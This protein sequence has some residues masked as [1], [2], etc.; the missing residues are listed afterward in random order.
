[1]A[2]FLERE[3]MDS[4]WTRQNFFM[5]PVKSSEI[6]PQSWQLVSL[7]VFRDAVPS[8]HRSADH[9]S[10]VPF[11]KVSDVVTRIQCL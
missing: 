7:G 9:L 1:M 10:I 3:H 6:R 2:W 8:L 4:F 5:V 11:S